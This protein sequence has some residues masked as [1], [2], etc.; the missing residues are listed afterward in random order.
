MRKRARI[1]CDGKKREGIHMTKWLIHRFVRDAENTGNQQVRGAYGTLA[2]CV[3]VG[4]NLLLALAKFLVGIVTGSVAV[5]ADAANNLSDAGGS[6][7]S[8]VSVRMAQ[9]PV[10]REHPYGHGRMEYIGALGVGVLILIMGVELLKS[11][12][13]SI[14]EPQPLSFG[15]VPFGVL[16]MSIGAKGW[17]YAFYTRIGKAID[18]ATLLAAAK[19]SVS[20]VLATSAVAVSMLAGYCFGWPVDGWMGT[21]VA[22]VVLKA[23]FD[24]CKDTVDSLLGGTPDKALG[25]EI[26]K[27]LMS[28]DKILGVHDL[29]MHDYG[30]GRC[31]ASVHAEV[32]ADGNILELHEIID[33]AEREIGEELHLPICIHMDPIVS[34]DP[35]TDR[36]EAAMKEYLT[37]LNAELKLHDFRR[38]PGEHQVNLIFDVVVPAGYGDTAFLEKKLEDHA[39]KLDQRNR[40]V[41]HFDLDYYN[42]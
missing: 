14:L 2:S 12:I 33:R 42:G 22:L 18:S 10:D 30:P 3:G 1:L 29:M 34:G 19:D 7:V 17:L 6:I 15:W 39:R 41:I 31:V 8:L 4:T 24:V 27:R 23:G 5:T 16:L 28:Y 25:Q 21:A 9:K 20:D 11:G 35:E 37:E 13:S 40:C 38:V 32:P 26:I 36:T